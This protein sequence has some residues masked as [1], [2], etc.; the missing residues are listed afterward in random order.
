MNQ[1]VSLGAYIIYK[2]AIFTKNNADMINGIV[3]QSLVAVRKEPFERSEMVNQLLFGEVFKVFERYKGWLRISIWHDKYEG[4][5]DEKLC[6][7]ITDDQMDWITIPNVESVATQLFS[8]K[9][10][11]NDHPIRL[12]PGSSLYFYNPT[13]G[14]FKIGGDDYHTFSQSV[15][16]H[17]SNKRDA[18]IEWAKNYINA[19]YLWGGRSPYG[20]DCSGLIQV[21]YK[22]IGMLIPRDASQQVARGK[23]VDFISMAQPGDLAFFDD[24]ERNITHVGMVFPNGNIIHSSGYVKVDK[25]DHQGIFSVETKTYSHKLRVIKNLLNGLT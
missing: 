23:T 11:G 17:L 19:P 8:A 14:S 2:N 7:M 6:M 10:V 5:I 13:E 25:L 1:L 4:W 20:V 16:D 24:E 21:V 12:C 3:N 15:D 18:L 22:M 9:K